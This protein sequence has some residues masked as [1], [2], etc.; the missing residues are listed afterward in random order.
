MV[1]RPVRVQGYRT[2]GASAIH[3]AET[4]LRQAFGQISG[5]AERAEAGW[6]DGYQ[7]HTPQE[8]CAEALKVR[9]IDAP[10]VR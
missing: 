3:G 4:L 9:G 6:D 8:K 5:V 10:I 2:I 1:A 7:G